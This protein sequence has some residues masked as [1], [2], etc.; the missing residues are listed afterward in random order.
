ML[1]DQALFV[2]GLMVEK[3]GGPSVKPPQPPGLWEAVAFTGSNT[4]IFRAD[5][6]REKVH[7]RSMY[8]FL[9]RTAHPPQMG[10]LDAPSREACTV[11][12]ERT[13]TPLQALLLMNEQLFVEA[14]RALA[15]RTLKEV[16]GDTDAR[17]KHLFRRVTSRLPDAVEMTV[18]R[19][20]L[21]EHLTRYKADPKAAQA[22]IRVGESQPDPALRPEELA[23]WTMV[24]NLVLNLDE[25][26]NR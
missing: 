19:D 25:V 2:S 13:N 3:L 17:L 22:L 12:R 11:R 21:Q 24:G 16:T 10:T 6:G 9:K 15:Q 14:S 1:R 4:G 7:R 5:S 18:L 8:T 26:I 23:A 20:T